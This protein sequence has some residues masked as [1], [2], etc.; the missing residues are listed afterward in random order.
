MSSPFVILDLNSYLQYYS[1]EEILSDLSLFKSRNGSEE[2]CHFIQETFNEDGT[3]KD[4][5]LD[6]ENKHLCRIYFILSDKVN[7]SSDK[8]VLN[9]KNGAYPVY[10]YFSISAKIFYETNLYTDQSLLSKKNTVTYLIGHLCK[11][12]S[13][14]W[15]NG[16]L[17]ML[18]QCFEII[19]SVHQKIG[20]EYILIECDK[21]LI[22]Y[23]SRQHFKEVGFNRKS[24]LFQM[25]RKVSENPKI[26]C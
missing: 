7:D 5:F 1:P 22:E 15:E 4:N 24:G 26:S 25:I 8:C 9:L 2:L 13:Y 20:I 23:Y 12:D 21:S 19:E 11:N 3:K 16:G 10:G 14:E 6:F 18:Q 17:F